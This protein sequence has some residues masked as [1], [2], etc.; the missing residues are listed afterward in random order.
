MMGQGKNERDIINDWNK[1]SC[2]PTIM[3]SIGEKYVDAYAAELKRHSSETQKLSDAYDNTKER[4]LKSKRGELST[5]DSKRNFSRKPA[6]DMAAKMQE[7]HQ[8]YNAAL[9]LLKV[10]KDTGKAIVLS[11]S[12]QNVVNRINANVNNTLNEFERLS[13]EYY[14]DIDSEYENDTGLIESKYDTELVKASQQF[15]YLSK[16]E[17]DKF[18]SSIKEIQDSLIKSLNEIEYSELQEANE[19]VITLIP[20]YRNYEVPALIPDAVIEGEIAYN[21]FEYKADIPYEVRQGLDSISDRFSFVQ[22]N[23]FIVLPCLRRFEEGKI[24]K[25]L[26]YDN[27]NRGAA[28]EYL[29]AIEMR[30]FMSLPGGKLRATMFDPIDSGSNF[31]MFSCLGDVD[32]RIISTKIWSDSKRINEQLNLL[33]GQIE[34]VIQDCLRDDYANIVEYNKAVGKNAEPLQA[35]FIADYPNGFDQESCSLLEKIVSSGQKCGIYTFIA[36]D[37]NVYKSNKEF[38]GNNI[39]AMEKIVFETG[40][41]KILEE[42]GKFEFIPAVLPSKGECNSIFEMLKNAIGRSERITVNFDEIVDDDLSN[43]EKWFQYSAENDID[44]PIGLEGASRK[45]TMH[46]GGKDD[47]KHHALISGATGSGKSTLLHTLVVSTILRYSPE[48]VQ[49]YLLDF[50][51][52]VEFKIFAEYDLPNFR[53]ISLDTEPEFGASVLKQ[54]DDEQAARA[55]LFRE[56]GCDGIELYNKYVQEHPESGLSKVP[57]LLLIID[58]FHEMFSEDAKKDSSVANECRSNLDRIIRQGR[59]LGIHAILASQTLPDDL[60][61][62]YGMVMNRVALKS[63]AA[64]VKH[65]LDDDNNGM[66]SLANADPGKGIYNDAAGSRD[67]N[68]IFRIAFLDESVERELLGRLHDKQIEKI[69]SVRNGYFKKTRLL[70]SSIQ[71][72]KDN[73]LNEFVEKGTFPQVLS[74]GCPLY[75]GEEI[76][77]ENNFRLNLKSQKMQNLLIIGEEQK[78]AEL[79]CG[80]SAMSILFNELRISNGKRLDSRPIIYLFDFSQKS[81]TL[82]GMGPSTILDQLCARFSYCF[83]VFGKESLMDGIEILKNDMD[84]NDGKKHYVIFF[85]LNRARRLLNGT[86]SYEESPKQIFSNMIKEGPEK[87]FNFIVWANDPGAYLSFYGDTVNEFDHRIVYDL[88]DDQYKTIIQSIKLRTNF[89]NNVIYYNPDDENKKLRIYDMPMREWIDKFM[90]RI[91]GDAK[92]SIET[93]G[94][95]EGEFAG[96]FSDE[97]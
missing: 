64:S 3:H 16:N 76:A 60:A 31:A 72:D 30:M 6:S 96:E 61:G 9:E 49:I 41:P 29:K 34:H 50:K 91:D 8:N 71:D 2:I 94:I 58:E 13:K 22:N 36:S 57:R 43:A 17:S 69:P 20:N 82:S 65:I 70:L 12:A 10:S 74:L 84:G 48:D 21:P 18:I 32:E 25:L 19:N 33:I 86:N 75:L 89:K 59:A 35:I 46:F 15:N 27:I 40:C 54:L 5:A 78:R 51:R 24:D 77:I 93:V 26:L 52:G 55:D 90:N 39:D 47:I 44:I 80:F 83:R 81:T 67:A 11:K 37:I 88:D 97:F 1:I 56:C 62:V 38:F 79:L 95:D 92:K 45:I 68:H 53:V 4:I 66:D 14:R 42:H 28:L 23:G 85:G 73:P 63:S 87:G 7:I